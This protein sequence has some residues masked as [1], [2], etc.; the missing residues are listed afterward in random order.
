MSKKTAK[1]SA[2]KSAK[3]GPTKPAKKMRTRPPL[4]P[5]QARTSWLDVRVSPIEVA[6]LKEQAAAEGVSWSHW[7]RSRLGLPD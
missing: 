7:V 2:K 1:K 4:P 3:N 5:G 6:R